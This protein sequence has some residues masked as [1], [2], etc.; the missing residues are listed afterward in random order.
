[1]QRDRQFVHG[2]NIFVSS[3]VTKGEMIGCF[4]RIFFLFH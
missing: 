2:S 1:M 3:N 4:A